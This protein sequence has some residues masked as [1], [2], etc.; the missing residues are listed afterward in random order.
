MIHLDL[1]EAPASTGRK[2]QHIEDLVFTNGSHGGLHAVE[3]LR[4]MAEQES[5][6]ELKW[7]GCIDG[8]TEVLT[9]RGDI[10]IKELVFLNRLG[11]DVKVFG[12]N[13]SSSIPV[14]EI[15]DV[16]ATAISH[17]TKSWVEIEFDNGGILRCTEDH[18]IFTKNRGWVPAG[19]LTVEDEIQ[20]M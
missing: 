8:D 18:Q 19:T 1:L 17:G 5:T 20:E 14:D 13:L 3:R 4:S 9:T 11:E 7:D 16:S 15:T 2:Y 6:I 10:P 12:R